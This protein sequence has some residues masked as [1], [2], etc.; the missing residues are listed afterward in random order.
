MAKAAVCRDC[1]LS[2]ADCRSTASFVTAASDVEGSSMSLVLPP[3]EPS[4]RS[5]LECKPNATTGSICLPDLGP[6]VW[7]CRFRCSTKS[8]IYGV[9]LM[10]V[11]ILSRFPMDSWLVLT[12]GLEAAALRTTDAYSFHVPSLVKALEII[13]I[14]FRNE[15]RR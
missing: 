3:H 13:D 9:A 12:S 7:D 6:A 1:D 15:H 11:L 8:S 5:E 10:E 14:D 2:Q 4:W